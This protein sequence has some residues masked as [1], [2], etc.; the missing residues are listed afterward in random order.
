LSGP[1]DYVRMLAGDKWPEVEQRAHDLSISLDEG[2][3]NAL[4]L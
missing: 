2:K 4:G 3:W 1:T